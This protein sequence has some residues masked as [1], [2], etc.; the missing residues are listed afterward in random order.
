[1]KNLILDFFYKF[2]PKLL[3]GT[4]NDG[5]FSTTRLCFLGAF[6]AAVFFSLL[7]LCAFIY[8]NQYNLILF[9]CDSWLISAL[10]VGGLLPVKDRVKILNKLL[11][12]KY[13]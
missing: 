2:L 9:L 5:A 10:L 12:K 13:E 11:E 6:S 1:M 8:Y 3:A 7:S 4:R